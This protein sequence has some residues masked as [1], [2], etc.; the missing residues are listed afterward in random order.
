MINFKD[1]DKI[2]YGK[3]FEGYFLPLR[4]YMPHN[5]NKGGK[6]LFF[7]DLLARANK[8]GEG[9]FMT[10][11]ELKYLIAAEEVANC[12]QFVSIVSISK[13]MNVS[14]VSVY[15]GIERLVGNEYILRENKKIIFTEKG[16]LALAEYKMIIR[17]I[18]NHLEVHCGVSREIAYNDA[19]GVACS[20]SD[21]SRKGIANFMKSMKAMTAR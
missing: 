3:E 1:C 16:R 6:L 5:F 17:F 4:A 12:E 8:N 2:N 10:V 21:E 13:K 7:G 11:S 19:L 18:C 20:F 9:E 15:R 14:K